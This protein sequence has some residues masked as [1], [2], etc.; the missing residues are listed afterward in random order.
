VITSYFDQEHLQAVQAIQELGA[1]L[2]N[3]IQNPL[4][5]SLHDA[6]DKSVDRHISIFTRQKDDHLFRDYFR[7]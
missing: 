1:C 2:I 3:T 7:L 4:S 5:R 6:P